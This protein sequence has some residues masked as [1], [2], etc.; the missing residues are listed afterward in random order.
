MFLFYSNDLIAALQHLGLDGA[1]NVDELM[2]QMGVDATG[3]VSYEQFLQC[4][5]SHESE[6][7]ALRIQ[8]NNP[9]VHQ[10]KIWSEK[11]ISCKDIAGQY[12]QI[13]SST[14]FTYI[15]KTF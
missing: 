5:L 7:D 1:I 8:A 12:S 9:D 4:R 2:Q 13:A 15:Y 6:I 11:G 10:T 3:K 14:N